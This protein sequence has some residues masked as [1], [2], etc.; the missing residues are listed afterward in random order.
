[1]WRQHE[2]IKPLQIRNDF[3]YV[4]IRGI[5]DEFQAL[6]A[7]TAGVTIIVIEWV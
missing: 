6:C 2:H 5:M 4:Y 1:M 3:A 7:G